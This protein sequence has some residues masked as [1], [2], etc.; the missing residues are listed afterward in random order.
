[1]LMLDLRA[2]QQGESGCY[3]IASS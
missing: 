1:M 2:D 3:S